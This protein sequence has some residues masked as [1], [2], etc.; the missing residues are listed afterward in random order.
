MDILQYALARKMGVGKLPFGETKE[1]VE[2][3]VS[4]VVDDANGD[5]G[6]VAP[7]GLE[8]G[9]TY[10]VKWHGVDYEVTGLD[11]NALSGGQYPGVGIGNPAALGAA[12]NGVPFAIVDFGTALYGTMWGQI[13]PVNSTYD[14]NLSIRQEQT[15]ITPLPAKYLPDT[16][17]T[18]A[19]IFGAMEAS[20]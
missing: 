8:V 13:V 3:P 18:K 6:L 12:D 4:A 16:V 19:D 2:L 17:A 5:I 14:D 9:E 7:I 10:I 20:Y 1:V 11:V 15:T